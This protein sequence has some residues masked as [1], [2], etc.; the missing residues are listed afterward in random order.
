MWGKV[1][2]GAKTQRTL[3]WVLPL[4]FTAAALLAGFPL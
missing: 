4:G 3:P 1:Q 2:Q